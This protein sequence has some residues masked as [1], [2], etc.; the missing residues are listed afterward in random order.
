MDRDDSQEAL[1]R[2]RARV[3]ERKRDQQRARRALQ[4]A[5]I[6]ALRALNAAGHT[7]AM[8]ARGIS[9]NSSTVRKLA[10]DGDQHGWSPR[11]RAV[12]EALDR[13]TQDKIGQTWWLVDLRDAHDRATRLL[14]EAPQDRRRAEAEAG[15]AAPTADLGILYVPGLPEERLERPLRLF[16]DALVTSFATG[17]R[18]AS[19]RVVGGQPEATDSGPAWLVLEP[20]GGGDGLADRRWLVAVA[21]VPHPVTGDAE[22]R[23]FLIWVLAAL[24]WFAA[25]A[26]DRRIRL[27]RCL[28]QWW[29]ARWRRTLGNV[30][31]G[32]VG[33][34][35]LTLTLVLAALMLAALYLP[36][37]RAAG[38]AWAR[39]LVRGFGLTY[40]HAAGRV[41]FSAQAERMRADLAWMRRR[42][43]RVAVV[44]HGQ[45]VPIA[46]S[47]VRGQAAG[48]ADLL[49][50]LGSSLRRYRFAQWIHQHGGLASALGG[51]VGLITW[52]VTVLCR[53]AIVATFAGLVILLLATGVQLWLTALAAISGALFYLGMSIMARTAGRI[54]HDTAV[55][56]RLGAA[57]QQPEGIDGSAAPASPR[58]L[59]L[60]T[61][62]DP[63]ADGAYLAM[64]APLGE[65]HESVSFQASMLADHVSYLMPGSEALGRLASELEAVAAGPAPVA[66]PEGDPAAEGRRRTRWLIVARWVAGVAGLL[67][68]V[69]IWRLPGSPLHLRGVPDAAGFLLLWVVTAAAAAIALKGL[70]LVWDQVERRYRPPAG[71]DAN[72]T[73]MHATYAFFV[74]VIAAVVAAPVL[75][76]LGW[77]APV[78]RVIWA[79][80]RL[81]AGGGLAAGPLAVV[82]LLIVAFAIAFVAGS[83]MARRDARY[84]RNPGYAPDPLRAAPLLLRLLP[85]EGLEVGGACY[86]VTPVAWEVS[87]RRY[88]LR[89]EPRPCPSPVRMLLRDNA[90]LLDLRDDFINH[91]E[92]GPA[93]DPRGDV[94]VTARSTQNLYVHGTRVSRPGQGPAGEG[95][96]AG[97]PPLRLAVAR[98]W[99]LFR[100]DLPKLLRQVAGLAAGSA[101][102]TSTTTDTATGSA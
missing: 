22:L 47:L 50:T 66:V 54:L 88:G 20:S 9:T 92:R 53:V 62:A 57:A 73:P 29:P 80:P 15:E 72:L 85:E 58:W 17:D 55:E 10:S 35:L 82:L 91:E 101:A 61:P 93:G 16:A 26:F 68:T 90:V 78:T 30:F 97:E 102:G 43:R 38:A 79:A 77:L 69:A 24:P 5:G 56:V 18:A 64:A 84:Q 27:A 37:L 49:V 39:W 74:E 21:P 89:G 40:A 41:S 14:A 59:D 60:A 65:T 4:V 63:V 8:V 6:E 19:V 44:A 42:C 86:R 48:P 96:P 99:R 32:L 76:L 75:A 12:Y 11:S 31:T 36:G 13:Y 33:G 67:T 83:V 52:T 25:D 87:T 94:P 51:F 100:R 28:P 23:R 46:H 70:W 81:L 98:D 45:G 2:A 34:P 3:E 7:S 71:A 95:G 1:R